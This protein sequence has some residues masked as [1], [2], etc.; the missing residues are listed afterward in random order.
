MVKNC[1]DNKDLLVLVTSDGSDK[2]S[3]IDSS[4]ICYGQQNSSEV[5]RRN[6]KKSSNRKENNNPN[7]LYEQYI[8]LLGKVTCS[9]QKLQTDFLCGTSANVAN[10][11]CS[12]KKVCFHV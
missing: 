11:G 9:L 5:H 3:K 12:W 4:H 7:A 10:T 1:M 6:I 8:D 2:L